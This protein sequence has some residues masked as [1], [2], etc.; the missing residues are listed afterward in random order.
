M[1]A[2]S[3]LPAILFFSFSFL[4][5]IPCSSLPLSTNGK[6]IVDSKTGQRV[7][8]ACVNWPAHLEPMVAE[9]FREQSL[10]RIVEQI[11]KQKYNCVRLTWATF[12]FTRYANIT[13]KQSF[14]TLKLTETTG[15]IKKHN[16][17]LYSM[18]LVQA[19]EAVIDELGNQGVM[20]VLDC[21]VSKP[22][23]CC[24]ERDGNAFFGDTSFD[25]QEW[26]Q[27][28][29]KVAELVKSKPH[30][31]GISTRNELRGPLS[32][33][34]D[35]YKYI[36]EGASAIHKANPDVL[37]F[38]SGLG[39]ATDLTFLKR[40]SLGTNYDNKLVY[41]AHWYAFSWGQ[42]SDWDVKDINQV[43]KDKLDSFISKTGFITTLENPF[44][45]FLGEFGFSQRG[46]DLSEDHFLSCFL[47]YASD[48]DLD[49]AIWGLQGSY[50]IRNNKEYA[51]EHFGVLDSYW[52]RVRSPFMENRLNFVKQKLQDPTSDFYQS[53]VI[54][55]P[56]SGACI[57]T[58]ERGEI[59]ADSCDNPN[60]WEH[61]E[62]GHPIRL[63]ST[64]LCIEAIGD[65]LSP[66]LSENCSGQKSSW[67]LLSATKLHVAVIDESGQSL[68]L[69]KDSPYTSTIL[70][71]KCSLTFE[72]DPCMKDPQ[73]DS[74]TQWFKLVQTNVRP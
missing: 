18:T 32:N 14:Q 56:Q 57:S 49:W 31:V 30:V 42:K 70:T 2:K 37:I 64:N 6:W 45:L 11:V 38:V 1:S 16:L 41:E 26:I 17:F 73:K 55:H 54:F 74:T 44:P 68:C 63:H 35:W 9:G 23:W 28:L 69:H 36:N 15:G 72:D 43:C 7:K 13:V 27:G 34:D 24:G 71:I 8:L 19:F 58:N 65:G 22:S 29:T 48:I 39:Y 12:M 52:N 40:Q 47:A 4:F 60:Q 53:Y 10:K 20:A 61:A 50:Y 46:L 67:K 66:V 33:V 5:S 62:D 21:Q 59:Y 51:D 3:L 25:V